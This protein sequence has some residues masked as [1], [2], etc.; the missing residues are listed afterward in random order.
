M[1]NA[2][3]QRIAAAVTAVLCAISITA[4]TK[5]MPKRL[6]G[7]YSSDGG[8]Q[9]AGSTHDD[10]QSG[11]DT[12]FTDTSD[13]KDAD[14]NEECAVPKFKSG[15]YV[16]ESTTRYEQ[17]Y[18]Q[19]KSIASHV[20]TSQTYTYDIKLSVK[21]NGSIAAVYTFK[22]IQTGYEGSETYTM[23]TNDKSGRDEDTAVYYDIIGQSFTVNVTSGFKLSVKGI[24][25][26][27]KNYPDTV[28]LIDDENMLE[29]AKDLFY[30]IEGPL[31]A[32]SSWK[33][34]QSGI[35]NTYSVTKLND[36]NIV[37]NIAGGALDVPDPFTRE[38]ITYTYEKCEALSGSLVI[39]R[40]NRMIQEQSSYQGNS[41][42][43]EYNGATY[44]FEENSSSLCE[45]K[46][47]K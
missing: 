11:E 47:A 20:A 16:M 45:I 27:H 19:G 40:S 41:G 28:D 34:N 31:T 39:N 3:A 37:V 22:R 24:D 15:N 44:S 46:K 33:L 38:E 18:Y 17:I 23:D 29:I 13:I 2:F 1:R 35:V 5:E 43:I 21:D 30:N 6:D 10:A 32:G 26:I 42:E 36:K 4:C 25:K 7:M 8:G 14:K 12:Q 9:T